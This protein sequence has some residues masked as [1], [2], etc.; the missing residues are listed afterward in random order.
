M[1]IIQG[2]HDEY[3]GLGI[4]DHYPLSE[5]IQISY[6]DTNHNFAVDDAT[7]TRLVDAIENYSVLVKRS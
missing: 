3:G 1:L 6:F 4:E 2:V 7:I 5:N